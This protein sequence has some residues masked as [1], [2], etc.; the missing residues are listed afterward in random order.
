[1]R[2]NSEFLGRLDCFAERE[3]VAGLPNTLHFVYTV[4][5]Y[6]MDDG[7]SIRITRQGV[8]DWQPIQ[9]NSP[10]ASGYTTAHTTGEAG[11][12]INT[13]S[14]GVRPYENAVTVTVRD[15][16]LKE[17]DKI[18][19]IMGDQSEG[20]IG[21]LTQTVAER[22][23]HVV[24]LVDPFGG[25][26]FEEVS[27]PCTLR[28]HSGSCADFH[29]ILPSMAPVG[30]LFWLRLRVIDA[31]GNRCE[32]F[33]GELRLELPSGFWCEA[34]TVI[35]NTEDQGAKRLQCRLEREGVYRLSGSIPYYGLSTKSNA[36]KSSKKGEP[37]VFWGDM[38]GQNNLASG[39]GS[40]EDSLQFAKEIGALDFTGWQGNDFEISDEN[41]RDVCEA[42]ERYQSD[43]E[44]V[45]FPGYEWSGIT[46]AGG[47]HNIYLKNGSLPIHRSSQ[48]MS[49]R[50][51][52][53]LGY[54][55]EDDGSDCY[56]IT[57]LWETYRGRDDMMAIP[58]IG[59]RH[60]NLD[61][62]SPEHIRV[63]EIHSH[64]GIFEWFL[65]EAVKRRLKVGFLASSD[66][67][68]SRM[69]LSY[70]VGTSS[71]DFGAT[72]DVKSGLTAVYAQE[73]TREGIWRALWERRCYATTA[74]RI[75]LDFRVNGNWMGSEAELSEP[76]RLAVSVCGTAPIDR[77][78]LFRGLTQIA[79]FYGGE[80]EENGQHKWVKI[81]WSGLRTKFRKKSV[82]WDGT[83]YINNGR[84]ATAQNYS[85][86]R[87]SEGIL[88]YGN[89]ELKFKSRT[90]GDE[91]GVILDI[92]AV[93]GKRCSIQLASAQANVE[94]SLEELT[95]APTTIPLG[96]VDRLVRFS[97]TGA[98]PD[99]EDVSD[100][101]FHCA[102]TD[103]SPQ[104][105]LQL[106]YAKV[107]QQ[108]GNRAWS[109]PV[110]V[111]Y[112]AKKEDAAEAAEGAEKQHPANAGVQGESSL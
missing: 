92:I 107:F 78:E 37:R 67:H 70:P 95:Q 23:H 87:P 29:I 62:Y 88:S 39:I 98:R 9:V 86:D 80:V 55:R 75:L 100:Y 109:S 104:D 57:Q 12:V 36:C 49:K 91:D 8:T 46:A 52:K 47:D 60:G 74:A 77:V 24:L 1:M 65:N 96:E 103:E 30:E 31:Y 42:L 35:F 81:V 85:I 51:G 111:T 43:G 106:Y 63:I 44:F 11:V 41:W 33:S 21:I 10:K 79:C 15:G 48:W 72:F 4:G 28:I 94:V 112:S 108:D 3:L 38:H 66:D 16:C 26:R 53:L 61:F 93:P 84:I 54:G 73:L 14:Q 6:G 22:E 71:G 19:L 69:G 82:L 105:G 101:D 17:N 83:V 59:G 45:T 97:L 34:E 18:E 32:D 90:S 27:P 99:P 102:Y 68:T 89:Q 64:H 58:H 7:G 5:K 50:E 25:N 13:Y 76:P 40:M 110:F 2:L 20:S 56:P